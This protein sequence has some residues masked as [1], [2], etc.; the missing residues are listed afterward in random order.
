LAGLEDLWQKLGYNFSDPT[1]TWMTEGDKEFAELFHE[2]DFSRGHLAPQKSL[3][4][5]FAAAFLHNQSASEVPCSIDSA[6]PLRSRSGIV[7]QPMTLEDNVTAC[8]S[9]CSRIASCA[10][11]SFWSPVGHCHVL[12]FLLMPLVDSFNPSTPGWL[13]GPP[14]CFSESKDKGSPAA[15]REMMAQR[16]EECYAPHAMYQPLLPDLEPKTLPS[17]LECQSWCEGEARCGFFSYFSVS[18]LCHLSPADAQK[19]HP[20]LNFVAGPQTCGLEFID[21]STQRIGDAT[22]KLALGQGTFASA[23]LVVGIICG[24]VVARKFYTYTY[25]FNRIDAM[26]EPDDAV[27]LAI[28]AA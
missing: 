12:G 27:P 17:V 11:F 6:A 9:R 18:G 2:V 28:A 22:I 25:N 10:A 7:G 16:H 21:E 15:L 8:Q 4:S 14:S 20:V 1:A 23:I 5:E 3:Q 19:L 24:S 13:S 26:V